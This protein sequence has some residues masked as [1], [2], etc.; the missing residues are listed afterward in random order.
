MGRFMAESLASLVAWLRSAPPGTTVPAGS[1][2]DELEPLLATGPTLVTPP[3]AGAPAT[4]RTMLWT[5]PPETRMGAREVAEAI[6]RPVS[7][8]YRRTGERASK[9]RLPHRKLDGELVFVAGEVRA[10]LQA[11]EG[12]G[13][14]LFTGPVGLVS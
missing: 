1:L 7:W 6:G 13:A 8:V 9:A 10:W 12:Q 14:A 3:P 11:H 2:A 5:V 4:W